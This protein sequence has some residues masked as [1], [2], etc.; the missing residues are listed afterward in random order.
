MEFLL[1]F[2]KDYESLF[3]NFGFAFAKIVGLYILIRVLIS[4]ILSRLTRHLLTMQHKLTPKRRETLQNML[5][6]LICYSLYFIYFL[7]VL[8][9]FG[10][11]I[12]ALLTGAGV[13]G[14][15]IV[16]ASQNLLKDVFNGFFIIL[17]D[18]YGVGDHVIIN[19][20]WG[21]VKT[22]DLRMTSLHLWTGQIEFIP[23]SNIKQV[24]NFSKENSIAVLD[25]RISGT[26]EPKQ[27]ISLIEQAMTELKST[28][29]DIAGDI[30][31]PGFQELNDTT[32]TIRTTAVC[33]PNTHWGV[34]RRARAHILKAFAE[35]RAEMSGQVVVSVL[36]NPDRIEP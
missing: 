15:A 9:I 25:I 8:P 24:T 11:Q 5:N 19:G 12:G 21:T 20:V 3:K 36:K 31:I 7:T 13:V 26:V 4:H 30:A 29:S 6:N 35:K 34:Q 22:V 16:F 14:I 10:I 17:E 18:Q 2:I 27:A 33:V 32:F 28:D 23:N 1:D